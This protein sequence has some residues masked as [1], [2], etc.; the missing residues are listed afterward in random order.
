MH[1]ENKGLVETGNFDVFHFAY[2]AFYAVSSASPRNWFRAIETFRQK[3]QITVAR[4]YQR[5]SLKTLFINDFELIGGEN[6]N[7]LR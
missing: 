3:G 7:V 2:M 1:A 4:L 5:N 6:G